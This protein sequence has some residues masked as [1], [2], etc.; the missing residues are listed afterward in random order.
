MRGANTTTNY[1]F[2]AIALHWL[3]ALIVISLF[4]LGLWMV[5]LTYYDDWYRQAPA[6]HKSIGISLF[7]LV[8]LRLLWR[9]FNP[10][11]LP[12]GTTLE[13]R[14]AEG[15]HRLL[16]LLLFATMFAGY[17]ISTADGRAIEVFGLF[18]VPATITGIDKQEDVA[19]W[20]HF[21]L[22]AGLIVISTGHALAAIKHHF[23]N[24]DA[25]LRRML[26]LTTND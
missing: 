23:I 3:T 1:G 2:I 6:L 7:I 14:L 19:G 18:S 26:R 12:I 10:R 4:T 11:P 9:Q 17:L 15:V 16:Y 20:I 25:T 21:W 22:A 24:R 5:E 8:V 13:Q